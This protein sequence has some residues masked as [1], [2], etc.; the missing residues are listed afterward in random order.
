[1]RISALGVVVRPGEC[2]GRRL[3]RAIAHL[4][5]QQ[6]IDWRQVAQM[7]RRLVEGTGSPVVELNR[8][9]A[10]A[11]AQA[12][13]S[14]AALSASAAPNSSACRCPPSRCPFVA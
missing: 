6:R 7:Y 13:D 9:V 11:L 14:W 4:Q 8:A 5:T 2:R 3:G 1:L 12:G 10:P